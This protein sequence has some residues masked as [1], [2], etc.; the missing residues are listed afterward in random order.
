M[1]YVPVVI[2]KFK[3]SH[4]K[5]LQLDLES[6][7]ICKKAKKQFLVFLVILFHQLLVLDFCLPH[8]EEFRLNTR[9]AFDG[10]FEK[11]FKKKISQDSLKQ[12][13]H[14]PKWNNEVE[15]L[16]GKIIQVTTIRKI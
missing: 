3:L 10:Y 8:L 4:L 2:K 16:K 1:D 9:K 14:N 11:I 13:K 15:L 5:M 7:F 6:Q 12:N